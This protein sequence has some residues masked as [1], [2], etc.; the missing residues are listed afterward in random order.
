VACRRVIWWER[1][2]GGS[3]KRLAQ[4]DRHLEG[5]GAPPVLWLASQLLEEYGPVAVP[6]LEQH[7][8]ELGLMDLFEISDLRT[9]AKAK[10]RDSQEGSELPAGLQSL[11]LKVKKWRF[12]HEGGQKNRG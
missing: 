5:D 7:G 6:I 2:H 10:E 8:C 4:L 11:L 9:Y 1:E 3:D 12:R